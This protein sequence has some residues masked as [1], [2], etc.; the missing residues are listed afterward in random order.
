MTIPKGP[1]TITT[2]TKSGSRTVSSIVTSPRWSHAWN[3]C[4]L[5]II[6][7]QWL[8]LTVLLNSRDHQRVQVE[9]LHDNPASLNS[10]Q[11]D[12]SPGHLESSLEYKINKQKNVNGVFAFSNSTVLVSDGDTSNTSTFPGVAATI[13]FRAPRWFYLRY[14]LMIH[15]ALQNIPADWALQIFINEKWVKKEGLLQ[16]HP[17]LVRLMNSENNPRIIVTPL[18]EY[19]LQGKPKQILVDPWFWN[20]LVADKVL[21]FSGNGAFCGNHPESVWSMLSTTDY[22]A[23]PWPRH[24]GNGGNA[25]T[26][27]YRNR[28]AMLE[29]LQYHQQNT[30]NGFGSDV[31][32]VK[33][34]M[35]MNL[36]G[37]SSFRVATPDQTMQ[38]G[39][40]SNLSV[41][42]AL[43]Y[44]P[45]AISGTQA[46]LMYKQRD[47]LLKHCPELK[48]IFPSLHEPSC[49]GAHP[50]KGTCQATICAMQDPLPKAGC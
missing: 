12:L 25:G 48:M 5:S 1:T 30:K 32:V 7:L 14:T 8:L 26:H 11:S 47:S 31:D 17:G 38:F 15:N 22:C 10:K 42:D 35:E 27:S 40:A 36:K 6:A 16:W 24:N 20:T 43:T 50:V 49:F 39:G 3:F 34:M 28:T 19:L 41:G 18:P 21:L 9:S 45:L 33:E 37:L 13:M 44:V 46:G 23:A 4:L 29:V 2:S